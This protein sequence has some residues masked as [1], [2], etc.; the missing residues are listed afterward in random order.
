MGRKGK[1]HCKHVTTTADNPK[2][3]S[4]LHLFEVD[5]SV[6]WTTESLNKIF[7]LFC[8]KSK[9]IYFKGIFLTPQTQL[10]CLRYFG[11]IPKV[12]LPLFNQV[13]PSK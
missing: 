1:F 2:S 5:I 11:D 10:S 6:L 8:G 13:I 9:Y 3:S 4:M 7:F 12:V